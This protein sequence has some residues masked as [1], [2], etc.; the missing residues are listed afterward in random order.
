LFAV[1]TNRINVLCGE[2]QH[3]LAPWSAMLCPSPSGVA[4]VAQSSRFSNSAL[5]HRSQFDFSVRQAHGPERSRSAVSLSNRG[6]SSGQA[7]GFLGSDAGKSVLP[8]FNPTIPQSASSQNRSLRYLSPPS[9]R[10]VTITPR[11]MRLATLSAAATAAPADTPTSHP[12]WR[13]RRRVMA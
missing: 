1:A 13:A 11:R 10:I 9:H 12:S 3:Q 2:L 5:R 6:S 8:D 4:R 7:V